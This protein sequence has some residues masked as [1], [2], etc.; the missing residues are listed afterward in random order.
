MTKE[1]SH[2]ALFTS[3]WL[4]LRP[5]TEAA[6]LLAQTCALCSKYNI[7]IKAD[8]DLAAKLAASGIDCEPVGAG[9][10]PGAD[11][12]IVFGGD[13]T[14][15]GAARRLAASSTPI[16]GVHLGKLGFL[17]DIPRSKCLAGLERILTGKFE[18][19]RRLMLEAVVVRGGKT[20]A[21][22]FALNE[23]SI[24]RSVTG[25]LIKYRLS[26]DQVHVCDARADGILLATP[27]GS[28]A[29]ALA[30]GGPILT[31]SVA[32]FCIA[33]ICPQNLSNRPI[34][35]PD[36]CVAQIQL[37]QSAECIAHYDGQEAISLEQ[38]D[39]IIMRKSPFSATFLHPKGHDFYRTLREKLGWNAQS[40]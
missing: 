33:P 1:K 18:T 34:V 29:Y 39:A 7:K 26:V 4:S 36:S 25:S 15:L 38:G 28:T 30:A 40:L 5:G 27:T 19:D 23:L 12:A 6:E 20:V 35:L 21:R 10:N 14:L 2:Q 32:A 9:A 3:A 16:C 22:N 8:E 13:G 31:P 24:N 11:L 17:T 37:L